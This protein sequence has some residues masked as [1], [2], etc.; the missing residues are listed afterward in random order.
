MNAEQTK[1]L[2]EIGKLIRAIFPDMYGNV[3]F[4]FNLNPDKK[5]INMNYGFEQS[6]II[7][8]SITSKS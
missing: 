7:A 6:T 8:G 5:V 3:Y 1:Q 2:V 4:R